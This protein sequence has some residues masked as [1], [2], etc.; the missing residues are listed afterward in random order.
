MY[1][2]HKIWIHQQL[3]HKQ[4]R[5]LLTEYGM[6]AA[7]EN[8]LS[9]LTSSFTILHFM[10]FMDNNIYWELILLYSACSPFCC[11]AVDV[12]YY[13]Q[14]FN[15]DFTMCSFAW[16]KLTRTHTIPIYLLNVNVQCVWYASSFPWGFFFFTFPSFDLLYFFFTISFSSDSRYFVSIW[17]F[18][19]LQGHPTKLGNLICSR[20]VDTN[21]QNLGTVKSIRLKD[22]INE[23]R[24]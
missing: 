19:Q 20:N 15:N 9:N 4:K 21:T 2:K 16:C 17:K 8:L 7:R 1:S 18:E 3:W 23:R 12:D 6:V 11:F 13:V 14:I 10:C 22:S 5:T 24:N